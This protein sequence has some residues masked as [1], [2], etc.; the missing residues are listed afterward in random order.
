MRWT[1]EQTRATGGRAGVQAYDLNACPNGWPTE[2][3]IQGLGDPVTPLSSVETGFGLSCMT[4][5]SMSWPALSHKLK[6][7]TPH[8]PATEVGIAKTQ[9]GVPRLCS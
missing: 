5:G 2:L 9:H 4:S 7:T 1:N 8:I 3:P 6:I